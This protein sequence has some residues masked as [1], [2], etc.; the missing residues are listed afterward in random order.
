MQ[1]EFL[2]KCMYLLFL[3]FSTSLF[4]QAGLTLSET[5]NYGKCIEYDKYYNELKNYAVYGYKSEM[6]GYPEPVLDYYMIQGSLKHTGIKTNIAIA[7]K[8]YFRLWDLKNKEY[9]YTRNGSFEFKDGYLVLKDR[10]ILNRDNKLFSS[11]FVLKESIVYIDGNKLF[12]VKLYLPQ[13]KKDII[14]KDTEIYYFANVSEADD[15]NMVNG[16]LEMSTVRV[17][18]HLLTMLGLLRQI[19]DGTYLDN[20]AVSKKSSLLEKC[21]ILLVKQKNAEKWQQ[22]L[23]KYLPELMIEYNEKGEIL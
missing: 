5:M 1:E 9:I 8:G 19:Q 22:I 2:K 17:Y 11:V 12:E 10:Y 13:S 6:F 20:K 18:S 3:Y 23:N 14:K 21:L 7:G 4:A 16:F 15:F